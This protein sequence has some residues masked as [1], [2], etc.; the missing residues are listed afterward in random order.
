MND[1]D[2]AC[3]RWGAYL[4]FVA[5]GSLAILAATARSASSAIDISVAIEASTISNAAFAS[6]FVHIRAKI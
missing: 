6:N 3:A 1:A 5:I 2:S 4:V